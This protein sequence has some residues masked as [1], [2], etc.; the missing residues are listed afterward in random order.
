[1]YHYWGFGLHILSE[2]EFPELLPFEFD[3][4]DVTI[5]LG[6]TP[7]TLEGDDVVHRVRISMSPNEYLLKI[8]DIANYYVSGGKKVLV[9][10][11][12]GADEKSVRLFMLSSAMAA[13]LHQRNLIPLHASGIFHKNGVVLFCGQSGAGKSTLVTA[14]QQ[15]GHHIFTDDVCVLYPQSDGSINA[16]SSYPM[17]K[18]WADS[19]TRI[20]ITSTEE[21]RIRP[22]LPKYARF[23]HD[24]FVTDSLPVKAVFVLERSAQI[25]NAELTGLSKLEAF[26]KLQANAYRP[27]HIDAMG[28][29]KLHFSFTSSLAASTMIYKISRPDNNDSVKQLIELI[30]SRLM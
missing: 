21:N 16:T 6:K 17:A 8:H 15:Q 25:T 11:F 24:S 9:E 28:K 12:P 13:V 14:L 23:F 20:G 4:P 29:R 19:L 18:L 3:V 26:E 5:R 1:M 2:I 7:E 27:A 30:T 10:I 22:Q